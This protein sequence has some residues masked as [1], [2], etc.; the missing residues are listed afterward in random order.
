MCCS[1]TQFK[2]DNYIES[3]TIKNLKL[4]FLSYCVRLKQKCN[5]LIGNSCAGSYGKLLGSGGPPSISS[6]RYSPYPLPSLSN[7]GGG[8]QY[9]VSSPLMSQL[10]AP[11]VLSPSGVSGTPPGHHQS[12]LEAAVAAVQPSHLAQVGTVGQ[13]G[14]VGQTPSQG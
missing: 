4:N 14:Q 11:A 10:S 3:I 12:H 7:T 8:V 2:L 13:V 6:H 1:L 9:S 5:Q